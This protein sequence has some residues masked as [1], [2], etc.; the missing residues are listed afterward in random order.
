[1][2][3]CV[4]PGE[5]VLVPDPDYLTY[6]PMV[7]LLNGWP[8]SMQLK[9]EN[10]FQLV[11]EEIEIKEPKRTRAIIIDNPANP[12]GAVYSKKVLEKIAGLAIEN[13]LLILSDEAYEK[14]VYKGK[15][16]SISSLNG[17]QDYVLTLHS[18]SKTYG[19]AGFRVG[20]AAGPKK[21][22]G[23]PFVS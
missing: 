17:M 13:D 18:F 21:V 1:M 15:H 4:D 3:R 16:I 11:P 12:T 6:I 10:G 5:Q 22:R 7:E 23:C 20:Y 2:L 8:L 9:Q 14:F 19:M